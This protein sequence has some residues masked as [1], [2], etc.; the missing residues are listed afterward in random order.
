VDADQGVAKVETMT[1]LIA[2]SIARPRIESFLLSV[3][4]SIALLLAC[5]GLYGV[6]AHSVEQ[7]SREIGIRLALGATAP[8]VFR[9]VLFDGLR[10]TLL[11]LLVGLTGA[12]M[13]TR[14][15]RTL[16]FEIQSNDPITLRSV[17]I[18]MVVVSVLACYWPARRAMSVDPA[19]ML[20]EE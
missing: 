18:H 16:L 4:G 3:S 8:S 6:I 1:E 9:K 11:G 19:A 12:L 7:R 13:L 17:T 20:R 10:L 5:I 2:G 14:Y 15:I